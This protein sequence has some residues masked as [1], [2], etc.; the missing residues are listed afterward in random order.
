MDS[1]YPP[2]SLRNSTLAAA[3]LNTFGVPSQLHS[4]SFQSRSNCCPEFIKHLLANFMIWMYLYYLLQKDI[5]WL[6]LSD[7][8]KNI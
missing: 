5:Y 4:F 6:V 8:L 2:F 3:H 7:L 1:M